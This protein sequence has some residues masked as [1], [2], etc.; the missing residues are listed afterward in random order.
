MTRRAIESEERAG[1]NWIEWGKA[2][3]V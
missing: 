3:A 1:D 2:C